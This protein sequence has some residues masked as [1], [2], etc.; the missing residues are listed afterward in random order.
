MDSRMI[1]K[2]C[3]EKYIKECISNC[4][5]ESMKAMLLLQEDIQKN[6]EDH[7]RQQDLLLQIIKKQSKPNF[8]REVGANLTGDAIFEVLLRGASR[9]FR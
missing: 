1:M 3:R 2:Y 9:I 5:D 7:L 4:T 8:W 6:N